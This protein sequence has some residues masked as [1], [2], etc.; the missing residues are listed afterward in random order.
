MCYQ[1]LFQVGAVD[2]RAGGGAVEWGQVSADMLPQLKEAWKH[3]GPVDL[4]SDSPPLF[5]PFI[6]SIY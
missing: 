2:G 5:D 4:V 1:L 6:Q 3:S